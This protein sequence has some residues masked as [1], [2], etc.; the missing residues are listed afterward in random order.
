MSLRRQGVDQYPPVVAPQDPPGED[1][2]LAREA[3]A[4]KEID[5]QLDAAGWKVQS[6]KALNLSAGSGVAVR[7]FT[8]EKPHGRV[9]YLLFLNGQPAGVIEAKPEGTPLVEV[10][11]QSGKYVEGLPAWMQ[12]PVYPLPFIYESTGADTRFTNGYD[13]DARSRR[14]FTFHRPEMLAEWLRQVGE[15]REVPTFR[16]RLRDMPPLDE[17]GLWGKQALAIRNLEQ[18]L[19]EDHPRSLIQMA[20]GSGK[21]FTAATACYRLIKYAD[22]KRILFLVDRANLGKQAKLEFDKFTIQETQRKFTAEYNVQHLTHN[23]IDATSRVCISTIQRVFSILKGEA[24]LEPELDEQSIHELPVTEP[25]EVSYNPDL[26]PETFDVI[27]IDECHRSIYGLWR[28]VLEYFDAHLIGLT[29]TP[30]KQTFGFFRQNLV[31]EYSHD[32]AVTDG[33]N[34]DFTVYKIETKITKDGSTIETGD[35][36]GYRDRQTRKIRWEELDEPVEYSAGQL[37]RAVVAQDQIRTVI[38]TFKDKLF[39]EL[40]PG[41]TTVP[42]TLIF[43]KDDSHAD[44]VVKIV[45]EVFSKGNQ[46]ATKIT[47]RS[48]DGKAEDLLQAF[49]NSMYP[50]IVVTV[51][52]I[53]TGTDVKPLECLVFMRSVKS[54]TYFEQMLGRGVRVINDTEFQSVTD[55]ARSKDRFL[56]VDAVGVME[57][58]LAE[59]VQPVE[60]KPGQSLEKLLDLVALGN[61]DPQVASSIAG[62]LARLDKHLTKDDREMLAGLAGGTDLATIARSLL[63]A[64]D[65]DEQVAATIAAGQSADDPDAV[66]ATATAML[67]Y[68]LEPLASNKDLRNAILDVRKSYEQTIDEVSKDQVLFAGHSPEAQEK[69]AATISSFREYL[70]EHKDEIRAL[71]VLYS[72]PHK[73]RLTFSEIKELARAIE[74][75]PRQWTPETLWRAYEVLDESKVR[76]SGGRML[77]DIVS[78]VRYT[79]HQDDELVPFRD[80]VEE[81]FAAWLAIQEQKGVSFTVE[82]LQWLTWMKE[83]VA[84]EL[85]INPESFKYTPFVEHGG[86]GKAAQVF[87]DRLTPLM[88]ELSEVLAA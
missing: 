88:D 22:A 28:Q 14:V 63:E 20:T 58:P 83:N 47:Y 84:A 68:A 17:R 6:R 46:F 42:K 41:R 8:L 44:D 7:E 52:M 16:A 77:T 59:T 54:R 51:D 15:N 25:V 72:R 48:R 80:Q 60:R 32:Q 64:V 85:G 9:D 13:P 11:H 27:I 5:K 1:A 82:Q 49:R 40:F 71:Q 70:E 3:K 43:A 74:R 57:T 61:K 2:Y 18:S 30:T 67:T 66:T 45:R 79:L 38:Q 37:D 23:T 39:T 10:E 69:A 86:I 24:D 34:V 81:R 31:M 65:P 76:G 26:P 87:G 12:P 75:P 73:E 56:V 78:L 29:A 33:V 4:R 21:T 62:R 53:A 36:A 19:A 55:D 50:R 35:F